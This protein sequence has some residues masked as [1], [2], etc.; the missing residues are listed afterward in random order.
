[1]LLGPRLMAN[2][3][4]PVL[5]YAAPARPQPSLDDISQIKMADETTNLSRVIGPIVM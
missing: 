1:M 2:R 5:S 4:D 3:N